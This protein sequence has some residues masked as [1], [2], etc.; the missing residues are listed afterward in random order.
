MSEK[1]SVFLQRHGYIL[2]RKSKKFTETEPS[3][4]DRRSLHLSIRAE[5]RAA[6]VVN[7]STGLHQRGSLFIYVYIKSPAVFSHSSDTQFGSV[8]RSFNVQHDFNFK[9]VC[10]G[11]QTLDV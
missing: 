1:V 11:T 10:Y 2:G 9:P 7:Y 8:L 6:A 3:V 5:K 4:S